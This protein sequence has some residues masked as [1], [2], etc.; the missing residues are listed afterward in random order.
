[1]R[2]F[3]IMLSQSKWDVIGF[4]AIDF[5]PAVRFWVISEQSTRVWK[6]NSVIVETFVG[7][8]TP[9]I[10]L[11]RKN[12]WKRKR[13]SLYFLRGWVKK[14]PSYYCNNDAS[15]SIKGA[16]LEVVSP[17]SAKMKD[18]NNSPLPLDSL[19]L[20]PFN[21]FQACCLVKTHRWLTVLIEFFHY[22]SGKRLNF[23]EVGV[24]CQF[25]QGW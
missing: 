15:V 5:A 11:W 18:W 20:V 9:D 23:S 1:M 2:V 22:V 8:S 14:R 7:C 13:T 4:L 19:S 12:Y 25:L 24:F 10:N 17:K 3:S 21:S 6:K 16:E